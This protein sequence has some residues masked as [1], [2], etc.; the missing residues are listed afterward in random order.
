[1]YSIKPYI[2]KIVTVKILPN[3]IEVI[4]VHRKELFFRAASK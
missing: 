2:I 1:M 4:A 3:T